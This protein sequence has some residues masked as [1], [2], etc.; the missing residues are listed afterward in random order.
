MSGYRPINTAPPEYWTRSKVA[1]LSD[2]AI[3]ALL[4]SGEISPDETVAL[5]AEQD[6][7]DYDASDP[8]S[9]Q[10]TRE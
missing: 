6:A 10:N 3:Q 1:R 4:D 7:R 8:C 5:E 2:D 9:P